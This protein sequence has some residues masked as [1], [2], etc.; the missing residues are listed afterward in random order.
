MSNLKDIFEDEFTK[1]KNIDGIKEPFIINNEKEIKQVFGYVFIINYLKNK[2][3]TK[4]YFSTEFNMTFSLLLESTYALFSGQCRSS[5]LLL[6]SA[7]E[8]NYKFV[9]ERERQNMLVNDPLLIFEAID[10]RFL[11]TRRKFLSD[12]HNCVDKTDFK[13]YYKSIE[14]NLTYYKQLSGV[15]HSGSKNL[16]VM[17]VEFFS[18]LYEDTILDKDKFFDL[19]CSV[20]NEVFLLNF[21]LVRESLIH[22]DYYALYD[23]LRIVLGKKRS[24]TLIGIIKKNKEN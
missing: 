16:P 9:L 8:A 18:N 3:E 21:F 4:K 1:I 11:E 2:V 23:L 20:L 22:W 7:Q 15:V 6:R 12:L 5:L 17:S 14:R 19:F 24:N 13:E 10:Y